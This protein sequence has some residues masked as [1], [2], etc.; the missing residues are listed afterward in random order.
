[1]QEKKQQGCNKCNKATLAL[2]L[3]RPSPVAKYK[4]LVPGG[5]A[6]VG[7]PTEKIA[8][9]VPAKQPTQ[10]RFALRLLRAG[11]VH[12]YIPKPPAGVPEW[13]RYRI[14][15]DADLVTEQNALFKQPEARVKCFEDGHSRMGMKLL[16]IPQ[17]H[18]IDGVWIAFS[19]N[20]WDAKLRASIKKTLPAMAAGA[21]TPA[22]LPMQFVAI[23]GG[24]ACTFEPTAAALRAYLLEST[25]NT[26]KIGADRENDFTFTS[27]AGEVEQMASVMVKAAACHKVASIKPQAVI[28]ADP[29]GVAAE[30][31]TIRLRRAML[32][33]AEA[34]L[35]YNVHAHNSMSIVD[36]MKRNMVD[37]AYGESL[38]KISPIKN[39]RDVMRGKYPIGTK[40]YVLNDAERAQMLARHNGSSQY[41]HM[42]AHLARNVYGRLIYPDQKARQLAWA[43]EKSRQTW[44]KMAPYY[45]EVAREKWLKTF[46]EDMK[47]K[48][49]D[50]LEKMEE[51]WWA[52]VEDAKTKAY[53]A[54]HFCENDP[55]SPLQC[56]SPGLTYTRESNHIH[57]PG[58]ITTGK[59][60]GSYVK[61]LEGSF[62]N[63]SSVALRALAANQ[64]R[65]LR[66]FEVLTGDPNKEVKEDPNK[67]DG[68]GNLGGMRDKTFDILKEVGAVKKYSW[69]GHGMAFYGLGMMTAMSAGLVSAALKHP[70]GQAQIRKMQ[71]LW[72]VRQSMEYLA[73]ARLNDSANARAPKVAV[74]IRMS[75][76][77]QQAID[78][79]NTRSPVNN[80]NLGVGEAELNAKLAAGERVPLTLLTDTEA[81]AAEGNDP[82]KL[83][84][85]ADVGEVKMA[86]ATAHALGSA[87]AARILNADDYVRIAQRNQTLTTESLTK[88]RKAMANPWGKGINAMFTSLDGR[89]A[90]GVIAVQT[91]GVMHGWEAYKRETVA[92]KKLAARTGL[93][94]SAFGLSGGL[95]QLL[96]IGSEV[97]TA[98]RAMMVTGAAATAGGDAVAKSLTLVAFKSLANLAGIAGG[99]ISYFAN[100]DSAKKAKDD[101]DATVTFFYSASAAAFT[102]TSVTTGLVMA[103]QIAATSA[104]RAVVPVIVTTAAKRLGATGLGVVL[105]VTVT[106]SGLAFFF[107]IAGVSL[108]IG[109]ILLTPTQLQ[110]WISRSY[111]GKDRN[112]I[113]TGGDRREDS[114]SHGDWKA[115]FEAFS[116]AVGLS[117]QEA[118]QISATLESKEMP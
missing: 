103:G 118:N 74:L 61:L 53:F 66:A 11:Y 14:T 16:P 26:L 12:V 105:G 98:S 36:G 95:F 56:H 50:Q 92:E 85:K 17:A 104:A 35:P 82:L 15:E 97:S 51:D 89:L 57:V 106:V 46:E 3:L 116:Q 13:T 83:A 88:L 33:R 28:L 73:D 32:M 59:V 10:S 70:I 101:K 68:A 19:A 5:A 31:N 87:G 63:E 24:S 43:E 1:M 22:G 75:I 100:K 41:A 96:A 77:A 25:I 80:Q 107:L 76:T 60:L 39:K 117:A 29:V 18:L 90:I 99:A 58:P 49:Y 79:R 64:D 109:A 67:Q 81:L 44:E 34:A 84:Q 30:L 9:I 23:G 42:K 52:A 113:I 20:L 108:Q 93:L 27:I 48:H 72:G 38:G 8:S 71:Y 86:G 65:F 6:T 7:I 110:R 54:L 94:D 4:P 55:N 91:L 111:F 37:A 78:I 115:E 69:M 112:F 45:D 114:F 21:A 40:F 2:L 102:L 47:V 62:L